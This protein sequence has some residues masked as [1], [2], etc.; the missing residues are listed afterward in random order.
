M[1][2]RNFSGI[3]Y[4]LW[5]GRVVDGDGDGDFFFGMCDSGR[6]AVLGGSGEKVS[7]GF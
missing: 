3:Q 2:G 7:R 5:S 1:E 6:L 4:R